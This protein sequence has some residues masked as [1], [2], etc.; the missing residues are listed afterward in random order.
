[1]IYLKLIPNFF[2]QMRNNYKLIFFTYIFISDKSYIQQDFRMSSSEETDDEIV[3]TDYTDRH[4]RRLAHKRSLNEFIKIY[5]KIKQNRVYKIANDNDN[6]INFSC[7]L[8]IYKKKNTLQYNDNDVQ[9]L[10]EEYKLIDMEILNK[11]DT[12][13]ELKLQL[14]NKENVS[15]NFK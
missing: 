14:E 2:R 7:N 11:Y 3:W 4:K 9:M 15:I 5:K 8:R 13:N 6:Q 12:H 10:A 1:M